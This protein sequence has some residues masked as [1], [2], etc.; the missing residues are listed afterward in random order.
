[1]LY[2]V[3]FEPIIT[4]CYRVLRIYKNFNDALCYM[5]DK[6]V[7]E[8]KTTTE[9]DGYFIAKVDETKMIDISQLIGKILYWICYENDQYYLA[10]SRPMF[11]DIDDSE[12]VKRLNLLNKLNSLTKE[13][14]QDTYEILNMKQYNK[15][16]MMIFITRKDL[17]R[18]IYEGAINDIY[19][20][21]ILMDHF[22]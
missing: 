19:N 21:D 22:I 11:E 5:L 9:L 10:H 7:N 16:F 6:V 13:K 3:C 17:I 14:L 12:F 15:I 2:L 1:M 20:I 8:N 18:R 4:G